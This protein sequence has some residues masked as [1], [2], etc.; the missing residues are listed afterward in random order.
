[1]NAMLGRLNHVAI[2]VP[3]LAAAGANYRDS[4]APR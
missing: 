1:M 2:A 3:D 4:L